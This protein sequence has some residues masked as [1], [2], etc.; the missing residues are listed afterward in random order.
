MLA[1]ILLLETPIIAADEP[2]SNLDRESAEIVRDM[3]LEANQKGTTITTASHDQMLLQSAH[4]VIV[5]GG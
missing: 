1:R 2:T 3:L 5:V 4:R